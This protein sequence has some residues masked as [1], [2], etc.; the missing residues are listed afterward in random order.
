LP[1]A[2]RELAMRGPILP[3]FRKIAAQF[4]VNPFNSGSEVDQPS[5]GVSK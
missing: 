3:P 4:N 2:E 5:A 1:A